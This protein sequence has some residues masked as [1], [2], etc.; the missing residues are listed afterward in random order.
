MKRGRA[1]TGSCSS[2]SGSS[3]SRGSSGGRGGGGGSSGGSGGS[4]G[5]GGGGGG[6]RGSGGC[7]DCSGRT[8]LSEKAKKV[9]AWHKV[10]GVA[11]DGTPVEVW[12]EEDLRA[13]HESLKDVPV[14]T[15]GRHYVVRIS[16][17]AAL[18]EKVCSLVT[19]LHHL[20]I[21][22]MH[23]TIPHRPHHLAQNM[24]L[25]VEVCVS[26]GTA[27]HMKVSTTL[28]WPN[29]KRAAG[30]QPATR[31]C[32]LE[33]VPE[34][35]TLVGS[36]YV[37]KDEFWVPWSKEIAPAAGDKRNGL[38]MQLRV[39][40]RAGGSVLAMPWVPALPAAVRTEANHGVKTTESASQPTM[41]HYFPPPPA[42]MAGSQ[43][44]P[45]SSPLS[46]AAAAA[47][48]VSATSSF[49]ALG[50][51][52]ALAAT[53]AAAAAVVAATAA[54][55]AEV[56]PEPSMEEE[57]TMSS[58]PAKWL[59]TAARS[60]MADDGDDNG[61]FPV[62]QFI[63]PLT[64]PDAPAPTVAT[65]LTFL[66]ASTVYV[67]QRSTSV[68]PP[69]LLASLPSG[70]PVPPSLADMPSCTG[71]AAAAAAAAAL[72]PKVAA[73]TSSV[74]ALVVRVYAPQDEGHD[75]DSDDWL[76]LP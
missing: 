63:L 57:N 76:L 37:P 3:G 38:R 11:T 1:S 8:S 21:D 22:F 30:V 10:A 4:G 70:M 58:P 43:P 49:F 66:E 62:S 69:P 29:G 35:D 67:P 48:T 15:P 68:S 31:A 51:Y 36:V 18:L 41:T 61:K 59:H 52:G 75:N 25:A 32:D 42:R 46:A 54:A 20:A 55:A 12:L 13:R 56:V 33:Y 7:G 40:A 65:R 53:P 34:D 24:G 5:G 44:A 60:S 6:R 19:L 28:V 39:L 73:A 64:L 74:D 9:L 17:A 71:A 26:S 50:R 27:K 16:G 45:I 14:I 23:P 2:S 72:V 47:A